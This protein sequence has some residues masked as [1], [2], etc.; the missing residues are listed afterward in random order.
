MCVDSLVYE[1]NKIFMHRLLCLLR[2]DAMRQ[3]EAFFAYYQLREI[4]DT[5]TSERTI[6]DNK[7][8]I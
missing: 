2:L 7:P 4:I 8:I 6:K 3:G 5:L 1:I